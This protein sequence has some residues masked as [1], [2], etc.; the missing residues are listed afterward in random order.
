MDAPRPVTGLMSQTARHVFRDSSLPEIPTKRSQA[1]MASTTGSLRRGK[2]SN[3]APSLGRNDTGRPSTV[4]RRENSRRDLI[5]EKLQRRA[6]EEKLAKLD[7]SRAGHRLSL[8][9][10]SSTSL[11]RDSFDTLAETFGRDLRGVTDRLDDIVRN[12]RFEDV[13]S[14]QEKEERKRREEESLLEEK[15]KATRKK[16]Q[17]ASDPRKKVAIKIENFRRD[18]P[19][20][21]PDFP[22]TTIPM[23]PV[24][25]EGPLGPETVTLVDVEGLRSRCLGGAGGASPN[26]DDLLRQRERRG[27]APP[28]RS[29]DKCSELQPLTPRSPGVKSCVSGV[30]FGATSSQTYSALTWDERRRQAN[31]KRQASKVEAILRKLCS[32]RNLPTDMK[33]DF[34]SL[35]ACLDYEKL[36][37]PLND[38]ESLQSVVALKLNGFIDNLANKLALDPESG[39]TALLK[40]LGKLSEA[41]MGEDLNMAQRILGQTPVPQATRTLQ[42]D[43]FYTMALK[44]RIRRARA[45]FHATTRWLMVFSG[46][47]RRDRSI[48]MIKV[49][50]GQLGEWSRL[51]TA[52]K[53]AV[54]SV[55]NI[56]Q[57]CRRFLALKHDR[58]RQLEK[59]WDRVEDQNLELFHQRF[60]KRLVKQKLEKAGIGI[61]NKRKGK[62]NKD[63]HFM[64]A[65][66]LQVNNTE[67]KAFKIPAAERA[68][69]ISAFY[70]SQLR[71]KVKTSANVLKTV[72]IALAKH[73]EMNGFMSFFGGSVAVQES[74]A[75]PQQSASWWS[76]SEDTLI[77]MLGVAAQSLKAREV[78]PFEDHP[79]HKD[80]P[81]NI[82]FLKPQ[83]DYATTLAEGGH[84]LDLAVV[85][86]VQ[87]SCWKHLYKEEPS[88]SPTA[89]SPG[90]NSP[91]K[92]SMRRMKSLQRFPSMN[93]LG[94]EEAPPPDNEDEEQDLLEYRIN[95][96]RPSSGDVE[97]IV[98]SIML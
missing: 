55:R 78:H 15:R 56:Q 73:R 68:K 3:S 49:T 27:K 80:L 69:L 9:M 77:Y 65:A 97:S 79:S 48:H 14:K 66:K 40:S 7:P 47:R 72:R 36:T 16:E 25:V 21:S 45:I 42:D 70:M 84:A 52:M 57:N 30:S 71:H 94:D 41:A 4:A 64:T 81:L 29:M 86:L 98:P 60:H 76:I 23:C 19:L 54:R 44:L 1:S 24:Q 20:D 92:R 83:M 53:K 96:P 13:K 26:I 34:A 90:A 91:A 39:N 2:W 46:V 38:I 59:D 87:R 12:L 50:M 35:Q 28:P 67:W 8:T 74:F 95:D 88:R 10:T 93:N 82:L 37:G 89:D 22:G 51:K 6:E 43:S 32:M 11:R 17:A 58:C 61:S 62:G 63:K 5:N 33:I 85:R 31:A 75:E 18:F